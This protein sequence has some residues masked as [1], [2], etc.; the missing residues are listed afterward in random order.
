M[1]HFQ[2][3]EIDTEKRMLSIDLIA[4]LTDDSL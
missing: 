4:M 1:Q 2:K 3:L